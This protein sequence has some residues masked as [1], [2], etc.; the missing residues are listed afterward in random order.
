LQSPGLT[1]RGFFVVPGRFCACCGNSAASERFADTSSADTGSLSAVRRK[2]QIPVPCGHSAQIRG[3]PRR[4]AGGAAGV[5]PAPPGPPGGGTRP[6][7][8]A[9]VMS[10][11]RGSAAGADHAPDCVHWPPHC[12]TAC[13]TLEQ[14]ARS[15]PRRQSAQYR[16]P[17]HTL[18]C[19]AFHYVP[20]VRSSRYC[21]GQVRAGAIPI[22]ESILTRQSHYST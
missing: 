15:A 16:S 1:L 21:S 22:Q 18:A 4:M 13:T 11:V 10:P 5:R 20:M 6:R 2:S 19:P 12:T 14:S 7:F 17:I 3:S 8:P 9:A